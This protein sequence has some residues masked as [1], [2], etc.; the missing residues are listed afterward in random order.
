MVGEMDRVLGFPDAQGLC[1]LLTVHTLLA[2]LYFDS[3]SL[4]V[5]GED[6]LDAPDF[7][8]IAVARGDI[9][10]YPR[11]DAYVGRDAGS[12]LCVDCGMTVM[13]RLRNLG[14]RTLEVRSVAA[15]API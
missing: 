11:A 2:L 14:P 8:I 12:T 9:L 10:V 1:S 7:V 5:L 3:L 6:L 15:A 13:D 4:G